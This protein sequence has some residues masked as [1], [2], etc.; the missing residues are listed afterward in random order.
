MIGHCLITISLVPVFCGAALGATAEPNS[1]EA[2][3]TIREALR[4][5][6]IQPLT[7]D[8]EPASGETPALDVL[9]EELEKLTV[10]AGPAPAL[11]ST[12]AEPVEPGNELGAAPVTVQEEAPASDASIS[13]APADGT[14]TV[15]MAA[16][17]PVLA[18]KDRW[19]ETWASVAA[20]GNPLGIAD[21]LFLSGRTRQA[22][23]FYRQATEKEPA[24]EDP[25]YQ[26]ALYQSGVCM[27]S[28]D[29]AEAGK[30]FQALIE[31]SPNSPWAAAARARLATLELKEPEILSKFERI[32]SEPNSL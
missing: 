32:N 6:Q 26:W 23:R 28:E 30:I 22:D 13:S 15:I 17:D 21:A 11:E 29:P 5:E 3:R 27:A 25:G 31:K 10:G 24:P 18:Q 16:P 1:V 19:E 8:A 2:A 20:V 7:A 14:G 12:A 4:A 9:I